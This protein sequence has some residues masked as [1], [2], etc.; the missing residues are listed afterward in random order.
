MTEISGTQFRLCY[1]SDG[2]PFA[3]M[4]SIGER[5]REERLRRGLT[6]DAVAAQTK[7]SPAMLEAIETENFDR[8]PG[9]FFVRSFV[10]QYASALALDENEF[11]D[12]LDRL[13]SAER[14]QPAPPPSFFRPEIERGSVT[15]V[16]E[17][18]RGGSRPLGSLIAFLLIM[19]ACSGIYAL[20]QRTQRVQPE[21]APVA[22]APAPPPA[23]APAETPKSPAVGGESP[24]APPTPQPAKDA[25]VRVDIRASEEVWIRVNKGVDLEYEGMLA[26]AE[27]RSFTA[28]EPITVRIGRP[29]G[30]EVT[31]NGKPTGPLE[32]ASSPIT[33][34]FTPETFRIV[35]ATPPAPP[36][37]EPL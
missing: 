35:R 18:Y 25:P 6:I 24:A 11:N 15:G 21:T 8:L 3:F 22:T 23:V 27:S 33:L 1:Y 26:P 17:R 20:W 34:E 10:K 29:A 31:W 7:I 5:L 4:T 19:A 32:P 12:E 2:I 36:E 13:T 9:G 30:V 28:A 37:N 16:A 14:P